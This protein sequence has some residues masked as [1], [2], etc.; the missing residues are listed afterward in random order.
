VA[1]ANSCNEVD[2]DDHEALQLYRAL[3]AAYREAPEARLCNNL[4]PVRC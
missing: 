1:P 4:E 2:Y 3:H